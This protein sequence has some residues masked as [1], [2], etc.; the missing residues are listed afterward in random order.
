MAKTGYIYNTPHAGGLADDREWMRQ[1]GCVQVAEE[2]AENE[3]L[4]PVWKLLL[5]N[6]DRGDEIVVSKL[7]NAVSWRHS[8]N[9]AG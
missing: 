7:S 1:Y 3:R 5:A 8:S 6:L 4:R 2:A 9:C